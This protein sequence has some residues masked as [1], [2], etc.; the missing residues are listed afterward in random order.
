MMKVLSKIYRP[1]D[2]E[3]FKR[4]VMSLRYDYLSGM[5]ETITEYNGFLTEV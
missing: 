3:G 5:F 1:K 2:I 4:L